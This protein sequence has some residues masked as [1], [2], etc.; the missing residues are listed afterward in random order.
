MRARVKRLSFPSGRRILAVSDIHGSLP[1]LKGLLDKVDYSGR[2]I[3]VI[4]GDM[5]EKGPASLDTLR[6]VMQL[7]REGEVHVVSGNCDWWYPILHTPE[8]MSSA[9]GYILK[10]PYNLVRQMCDEL[11]V[12]LRPGFDIAGLR[13]MLEKAFPAEWA[14]LRDMPEVLE[15]EHYTFVHGGLPEGPE[16]SWDAWSCMKYDHFLLSGRSFSK[17]LICGHWPVVLYGA[18]RVCANP[19][20][21]R[22]KKIISIDGGCVLKDDGQLNALIIPEDGSG[23]F[24]FAA[25][26]SFPTAMVEDPQRESEKSFYIRWGDNRVEVIRRDG[27]FCRCR[28]IPSGYEMDIL[29]KYIS[30]NENGAFVNDCSDYVLPLEKGDTVSVVETTGRGYY[31]KHNGVSGWYYG[32]LTQI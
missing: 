12:E 11:G 14:F 31:V 28:H 17:W 5:L 10:K 25:Y 3:L 24:S 8:L 13:D 19:I 26:D 22:E 4:V 15:T 16:E 18:G 20:I 6:Y 30:E 9:P 32:R 2:D 7:S 1:Y 21:D 29:T 23:D 27:E